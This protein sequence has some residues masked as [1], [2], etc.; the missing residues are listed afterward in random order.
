MHIAF[1][2][3]M[4]VVVSLA[5][6]SWGNSGRAGEGVDDFRDLFGGKLSARKSSARSQPTLLQV[7]LTDDIST[8]PRIEGDV[9]LLSIGL[10]LAPRSYTYSMNPSFDGATR[11]TLSKATVGVEPADD[12]FFADHE[13]HSEFVADFN[14]TVEKFT[15]DSVT[16]S[17]RFRLLPG[18]KRDEF[19]IVGRVKYQICNELSC[20]PH[21]ETFDVRWNAPARVV[22]TS[23]AG[24]RTSSDSKPK[25]TTDTR[26][27]DQPSLK[28]P[29]LSDD[30]KLAHVGRKP[31]EMEAVSKSRSPEPA[32]VHFQLSPENAQPGDKVTLAVRMKLESGWHT[33]AL[34]HNPDN[35]G[36]PTEIEIVTNGLKPA[37][38]DFVPN[39]PPE[40]ARTDE[41][42]EQ[43]VH[44]DEV[45]WTRTLVVELPEYGVAGTMNYQVCRESCRP[46]KVT[47]ALGYAPD[48]KATT[49]R[50]VDP[51]TQIPAKLDPPK[52]DGS[53]DMDDE[54]ATFEELLPKIAGPFQPV[55]ERPSSL[56]VY[57]L[58]AFLGGLILNIMPCVLPVI[59]IKVLSFV[60]QAGE[61][62]RRILALNLTYSLG[63]VLVFVL[64]ASLAVFAKLGWGNLFQKTEFQVAM[65]CLVFAM[66]LSLMG[67]FEIP[68]PGLIGSAASEQHQEGLPGAFFTGIFATLLATPCS[69][70]FLGV[71]LGW[72]VKQPI[73]ITYLVW[74]VM[75]VGMA[76][77]YVLLGFFPRWVKY[78]PKPGNWM[79]TFKQVCGFVLMATVIFLMSSLRENWVLPLLILLLAMGF[80]LWMIG[81]LYHINSPNGRRW[82]V[83]STAT[84][85]SVA[86][87]WLAMSLASEKPGAHELKWEPFTGQRVQ[88]ELLSGRTVLIDFT[89]KWCAT[90]QTVKK[91]ALNTADTKELVKQHNVLTL[92]ADWTGHSPEVTRWL[93]AVDSESIPV[94]MIF[95]GGDPTHPFVL[96]DFYSKQTLLEKLQQ[97]L[98]A[99]KPAEQRVSQR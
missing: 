53:L 98:A 17:Q 78:L 28:A 12:T 89:A 76:S 15:D 42:K 48:Q 19:R 52:T 3:W 70:P 66:G 65:S 25:R 92:K 97:A 86:G 18:V 32:K 16:W 79:V 11:V 74:F 71:T 72:S 95:P 30:V 33:F 23:R 45:T 47:F 83:R 20:T 94:L 8:R 84:L 37:T 26:E 10:K 87:F 24:E 44:H 9:V 36:N 80:S 68:V 67:V 6:L 4:L 40:I 51:N 55:D 73:E 22:L 60:Q 29:R 56:A 27:T 64:L 91:L 63:V 88:T 49:T 58:Y 96:R 39:M 62:R 90:C 99:E 13:P 34:D 31:F 81:N 50:G 59:A 1:H 77:P 85:T 75:G 57:L 43:R 41:G 14:Q 2:R 21:D 35:V 69:G 46:K 38:D 54:E 61:S 7:S 82:F 5:S 93:S